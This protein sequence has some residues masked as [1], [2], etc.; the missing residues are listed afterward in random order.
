VENGIGTVEIAMSSTAAEAGTW[1]RTPRT[2]TGMGT[3]T[4]A[5]AAKNVIDIMSLIGIEIGITTETGSQSG[6]GTAAETGT[7]SMIAM[8]SDPIT[9]T[10]AVAG[11]SSRMVAVLTS[12]RTEA[13]D[14]MMTGGAQMGKGLICSSSSHHSMQTGA[15]LP[16]PATSSTT[17]T[18]PGTYRITF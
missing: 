7:G 16:H 11:T 2:E 12:S 13:P 9:Q 8:L 15:G 14:G 10:K 5:I 3:E 4:G 17:T 1:K 6:I 18:T